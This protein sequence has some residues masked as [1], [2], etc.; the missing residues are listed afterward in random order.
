MK[1]ISTVCSKEKRFKSDMVKVKRDRDYVSYYPAVLTDVKLRDSYQSKAVATE[2]SE[3][4]K[5]E[6]QVDG[7]VE[8][9]DE[10]DDNSHFRE[11]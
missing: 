8:K 10:E 5:T 6:D 7:V 1:S 11:P 3:E 4:L 9:D 2:A